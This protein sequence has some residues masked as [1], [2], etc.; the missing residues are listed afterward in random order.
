MKQPPQNRPVEGNLTRTTMIRKLTESV[1]Y[2]GQDPGFNENYLPSE[3]NQALTQSQTAARA[4]VP[5]VI[6]IPARAWV[7]QEMG[8]PSLAA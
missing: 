1:R 4:R 6:G 8:I 7:R 5:R 3:K 2:Q